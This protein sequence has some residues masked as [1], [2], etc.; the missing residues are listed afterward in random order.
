MAK[1]NAPLLSFDARGAIAKAQVYSI[2]K[3]RSYARRYVVPANPRST[4]QTETRDTFSWLNNV[5][6]FYPSGAVAAWELYAL[7]SRFTSRNGFIKVNLPGLRGAANLTNFVF[8]PSAGGG[9]PAASIGAVAGVGQITVSLVA[10][11][12]PSGWTITRG[13]AAVIP[14]QDPQTGDMY[15]VSSGEDLSAPY[16]IAITGLN[17]GLPYRVGGW[18]EYQKS[19]TEF[20]YGISLQTQATPT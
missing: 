3:G 15:R 2:W 16:S 13:V 19:P 4:E 14:E 7:N 9:L 12:L 17:A 10:P 11:S 18:F 20:A 5:W 1:T 6:K 8:S